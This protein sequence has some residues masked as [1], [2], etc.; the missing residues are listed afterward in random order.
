[1]KR[2]KDFGRQ[3]AP[4][5]VW[6]FIKTYI[7]PASFSGFITTIYNYLHKFYT[8][9]PLSITWSVTMFF[10]LFFIFLL[11]YVFFSPRKK[12]TEAI[13]DENPSNVEEKQENAPKPQNQKSEKIKQSIGEIPKP[14]IICTGHPFDKNLI[15]D[16]P[17]FREVSLESASYNAMIVCF[18]N[19]SLPDRTTGTAE[20]VRAEI[21]YL[22]KGSDFPSPFELTVEYGCW[23]NEPTQYV[24]FELQ[25]RH[26]LILGLYKRNN[27]E[28]SNVCDLVAYKPNEHRPAEVNRLFS[29]QFIAKV[30]LIVGNMSEEFEFSFEVFAEN[31]TQGEPSIY[32]S[33]EMKGLL[34][35]NR[36]S[37]LEMRLESAEYYLDKSRVRNSEFSTNYQKWLEGFEN[38]VTQKFDVREALRLVNVADKIP[39]PHFKKS[40]GKDERDAF[41]SK[42]CNLEK[43]L[44]ELK[45]SE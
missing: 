4:N 31:Q 44:K 39:Y 15:Y 38:Y 28:I 18:K 5:A 22:P 20:N 30:T 2:L 7:L 25:Q 12:Q 19:N 17:L 24:N 8:E 3:L 14:N 9:S 11:G 26:Y 16:V 35:Q 37:Q 42:K 32:L 1:M 29:G 40:A 21:V 10:V 27:G 13:G 45:E 6:D 33:S 34:K 43:I 41:Y 36:I 23:V